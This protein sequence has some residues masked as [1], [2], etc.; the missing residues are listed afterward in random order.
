M[1]VWNPQTSDSLAVQQYQR[2]LNR[3]FLKRIVFRQLMG[4]GP[5]AAFQVYD[6]LSS[7]AGDTINYGLAMQF[8]GGA[9]TGDTKLKGNERSPT[10]HADSFVIDLVRDAVAVDTKMGAQRVNYDPREEASVLLGSHLA[11]TVEVSAFN[12][13]GGVPGLTDASLYGNNA[14]ANHQTSGMYNIVRPGTLSTDQAVEADTSAT[15]DRDLVLKAI[16]VAKTNT[17]AIRPAQTPWGELYV[18]IIHPTQTR[19]LV[20]STGGDWFTIMQAR[21]QGGDISGNPLIAGSL[22]ITDG[23]LFLESSYIP[24]GYHSSTDAV[25]SSVRRAVLLGAQSLAM[26][27]GRFGGNPNRFEWVEEADDYGKT[28]GIA[29]NMIYGMKAPNFNSNVPNHIILPSYAAAA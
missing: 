1:S 7:G 2:G 6:E 4:S 5:D 26:G 18:C 25:Q 15:F 8:T 21:L 23:V 9:Y 17:P 14:V 11:R 29:G 3:E 27:F 22:G 13:L 28:L 19:S 10:V 20:D 24:N 16:E 12:H